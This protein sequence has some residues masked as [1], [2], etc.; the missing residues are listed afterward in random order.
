MEPQPGAGSDRPTATKKPQIKQQGQKK[1]KKKFKRN[2]KPE[3]IQY[4]Y[5]YPINQE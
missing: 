5:I 3:T 4:I 2:Q 1:K